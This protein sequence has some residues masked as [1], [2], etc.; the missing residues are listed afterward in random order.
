MG[1]AIAAFNAELAIEHCAFEANSASAGIS[2]G[3]GGAVWASQTDVQVHYS[4]FLAN[5]ATNRGGALFVGPQL[6]AQPAVVAFSK[7]V[8]NTAGDAGGAI[9]ASGGGAGSGARLRLVLHDDE[10]TANSAAQFG[11]ALATS[12]GVSVS[13]KAA[14]FV[15]NSDSVRGLGKEYVCVRALRRARADALTCLSRARACA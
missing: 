9:F 14:T 8:R 12:G 13:A 10:L 5:A 11:G 7:F 2:G 1:G 3:D 4:A 6:N 15:A